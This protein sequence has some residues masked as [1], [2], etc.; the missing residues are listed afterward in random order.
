MAR[1]FTFG[2]YVEQSEMI[3]SAKLGA[4]GAKMVDADVGH[5]VKL[6][7]DSQFDKCADGNEIEGFVTSVEQFTVQDH[8]FGGVQIG[9][10]KSVV[11]TGP[12]AIG[13]YVVASAAAKKLKKQ[14]A[15]TANDCTTLGLY[16]WRYVSGE[17]NGGA[18]DCVGV[19]LRTA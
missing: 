16:K 11:V 6:A 15:P 10:F 1:N 17:V 9:G 18:V 12:I 2:E 3:I 8:S 14:A 4:T 13:D 5:A 7:A 19:V